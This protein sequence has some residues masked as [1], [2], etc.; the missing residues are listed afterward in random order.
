LIGAVVAAVCGGLLL[1]A[2]QHG[3]DNATRAKK[4]GEMQGIV[5]GFGD[6]SSFYVSPYLP[7]DARIPTVVMRAAQP[8]AIGPALDGIEDALRQYPP[9]F[10][11][12]LIKAIF[13][14]G[15][16][17]IAGAQ[18]GGTYGPAWVLLSAPAEISSDDIRLTCRL[19]VHHEFSSFV[20]FHG[21]N[22]VQWR[23][24]EP[25]N[26]SFA[27]TPTAQIQQGK[28]PPPNP[29]TGFLSAYGATTPENDFNVYAEKMMTEMPEVMRLS[30]HHPVVAKKAAFVRK[31]YEAIDPR[32]GAVFDALG[33]HRP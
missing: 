29:A 13:V 28:S 27:T 25:G 16:M 22:A 7:G 8:E 24:M 30:Q 18:A 3:P 33:M 21:D 32:M 12:K 4:L 9:G 31:C 23:K 15:D 10:M 6:P 2:S 26:W 5:I 20:Y 11:N 19:G 14:C 1:A 17:T